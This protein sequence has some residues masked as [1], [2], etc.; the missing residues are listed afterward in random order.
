MGTISFSN[1]LYNS[2]L[3]KLY[4]ID[5]GL[6]TTYNK[7]G[8][9]ENDYLLQH[10]YPYFKPEFKIY[11]KLILH[12]F[13]INSQSILCNYDLYNKKSYIHFMSQF[14]DIPTEIDKLIKKSLQNK[15]L[16]VQH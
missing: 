15:D 6:L 8:T 7:I 11:S 3:N 4:I 13:N 12:N 16:F 9:I 5:F 2:E 10:S 1:I 14:I